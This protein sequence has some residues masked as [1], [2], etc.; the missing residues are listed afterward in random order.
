[1][2]KQELVALTPL[3]NTP[4]FRWL[5]AK[6]KV[7]TRFAM[8]LTKVPAAMRHVDDVRYEGGKIVIE[9]RHASQRVS[10]DFANP[11]P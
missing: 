6:S 8:F 4:T 3:F 5:P 7:S 1:M 9:D 11:H 10:L 2:T